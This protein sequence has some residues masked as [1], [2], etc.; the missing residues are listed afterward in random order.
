MNNVYPI[1]AKAAVQYAP[2]EAPQVKD[3][4]LAPPGPGEVVVKI[5]ATGICH[6]DHSAP[7][8]LTALPIIPGHEGAGVVEFVGAAVTDVEVGDHVL[9]SF[10]SCGACPRCDDHHPHN[11]N[12]F[13]LINFGA[14][15]SNGEPGATADGEP[16]FSSFFKQSSFATHTVTTS[17]NLVKIDK[18]LPLDLYSPL[19]CGF[20]TG[21]GTVL[22]ELKPKAGSSIV[23]FG[24]GAVGLA[25]VMA[26]IV[27]ECHPIIVVDVNEERLILAKELGAT[28]VINP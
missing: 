19:G 13:P 3:V 15:R 9:M 6:T 27:S 28:N 14:V 20:I 16:V 4:L 22:N 24:V 2:L 26:A 10:G 7:G 21:A 11:C 5:K 8:V 25:A 23:V 18:D 17:T 1:K 12:S